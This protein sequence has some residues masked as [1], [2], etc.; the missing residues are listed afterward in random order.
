VADDA[1]VWRRSN[2]SSRAFSGAATSPDIATIADSGVRA[3]P[4]FFRSFAP[5]ALARASLGRPPTRRLEDLPE[6][7][8]DPLFPLLSSLP[9]LWSRRAGLQDPRMVAKLEKSRERM[10]LFS[11]GASRRSDE[12]GHRDLYEA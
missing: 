7:I 1:A 12:R 5:T 9:R 8:I 11:S 10:P 2:A 3:R 6:E 4:P